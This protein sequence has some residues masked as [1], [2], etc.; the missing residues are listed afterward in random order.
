MYQR[1]GLLTDAES[2]GYRSATCT[3]L[4][5]EGAIWFWEAE[6]GNYAQGFVEDVKAW[7]S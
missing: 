4:A 6:M 7:C 3:T 1:K 2:A 5:R